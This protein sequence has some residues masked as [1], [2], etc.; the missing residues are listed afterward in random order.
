MTHEI[1]KSPFPD[2]VAHLEFQ[3]DTLGELAERYHLDPAAV[4]LLLQFLDTR[5]NQLQNLPQEADIAEVMENF[6]RES[7]E[8][9]RRITEPNNK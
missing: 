9:E 7:A 6:W 4:T 8:F 1:S 5:M 2:L 3:K